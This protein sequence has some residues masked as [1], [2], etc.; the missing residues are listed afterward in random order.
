[1][2]AC[3]RAAKEEYRG[4]GHSYVNRGEAAA[5]RSLVLALLESGVRPNQIGVLAPY[6]GQRNHLASLLSTVSFSS[7]IS[8]SSVDGFQG[9]EKDIIIFSCVRS[10][11]NKTIGFL[12]NSRRVNVAL[13]RARYCL[14]IVG[15]ASLLSQPRRPKLSQDL[16]SATAAAAAAKMLEKKSPVWPLLLQHYAERNAIVSGP[17]AALEQVSLSV[18]VKEESEANP[19]Q[20][21]SAQQ[22]ACAPEAQN[23]LHANCH[24]QTEDAD[25]DFRGSRFDL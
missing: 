7:E 5:V 21:C 20:D 4:P 3:A 1:M 24:V 14:I 18:K 16:P 19:T 22:A 10:N 8:L 23:N 13:T 15:N 6:V 17:L 11:A 9:A 2:I 25:D 12:D